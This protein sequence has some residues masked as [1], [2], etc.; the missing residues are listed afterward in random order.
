MNENLSPSS[1]YDPL[2]NGQT[3][4]LIRKLEETIKS[5]GI[6]D[7]SNYDDLHVPFKV[8]YMSSTNDATEFSYS[9]WTTDKIL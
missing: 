9:L 3:E 4:M 1:A 6:C 5:F 8:A 7:K 2:T